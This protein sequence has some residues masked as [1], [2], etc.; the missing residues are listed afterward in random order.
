MIATDNPSTWREGFAKISPT[1][2]PCPGFRAEDWRVIHA[3][4]KALLETRGSEAA[5]MGWSGLS[6]FGVHGAVGAA[7]PSACG[8]LMMGADPAEKI[9]T[10]WISFGRTRYYRDARQHGAVLVWRFGA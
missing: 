10:E 7:N 8:A 2:P 4:A 9:T 1:N 3:N 5:G 6:L